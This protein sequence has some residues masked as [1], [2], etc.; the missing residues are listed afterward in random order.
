MAVAAGKG[1]INVCP[2]LSWV[3]LKL[4]AF[5]IASTVTPKVWAIVY[6]LSPDLTV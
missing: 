4:L 5:M 2:T 1:M 3:P 6:K